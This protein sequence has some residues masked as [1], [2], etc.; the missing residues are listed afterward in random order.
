MEGENRI[1]LDVTQQEVDGIISE[2]AKLKSMLPAGLVNRLSGICN[3]AR[4][5]AKFVISQ[6]Q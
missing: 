2:I 5:K 1:S 4:N 6:I 3:A